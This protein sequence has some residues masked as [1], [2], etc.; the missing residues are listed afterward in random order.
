PL[1]RVAILGNAGGTT[2]RAMGVFYPQARIDGVELDPDVTA[3]GR[4]YFG[5]DDNPRLH[6]VT[7]DARPFLRSTKAR[8]DLI[9]VDAYRPPYVPFYLA[10]QEFFRLARSRLAPGGAI[11]LNVGSTPDDHRLA[12]GVSG[13]LATELPLVLSHARRGLTDE[14]VALD[15]MLAFLAENGPTTGILADL[16]FAGRERELVDAL[17]E[18]GLVERA[19]VSTS[20]VTTLQNLRRLE[21][22]LAR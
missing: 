2:A 20:H 10:T 3:V 9:V 17:R 18:H 14:P 11:V 13:T 1:R 22:Q 19:I 16:K 15:D 12:E 8:Y 5:L 7:A 21:P 6:V 4:R